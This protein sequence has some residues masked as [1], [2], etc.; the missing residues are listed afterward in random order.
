M[1]GW[2]ERLRSPQKQAASMAKKQAKQF[3]K[4]TLLSD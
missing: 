1:Q 4:T 3:I 2:T